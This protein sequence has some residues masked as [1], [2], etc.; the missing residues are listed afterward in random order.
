MILTYRILTYFLYPLI[1]FF[2]YFRI[3]LKKEDP[4]RF[5]EKIFIKYFNVKKSNNLKLLWF[6]AASIGEFKSIVPLIKE[7]INDK[8]NY[9]F[10]ITTTTMSSSQL[11]IKEFKNLENVHHRFMP[12][13]T[14][15]LIEN[16]LTL[17]RPEKIFLVDSEVWP[18]LILKSKEKKIPIALL[19][20][21][22]TKKSFKRWLIFPSTARKIFRIFDLCMCSN[23]ETK[24]FLEKLNAKNIKFEGN[25]KLI[26]KI[27]ENQS[28]DK[29]YS[30]LNKKRFW[31]AASIH[32]EEDI[33]CLKTH[34]EIKKKF[35]DIITFIAPRH[36]DRVNKI[37][38]LSENLNLST[39]ILNADDKILND[40][41]IIII[42]S[43]GNLQK[44]FKHAK[45][46]FIGK[47]TIKKLQND[48]GQ[49][50]IDAA[51]LGCKIYHGPYV[52][53]FKEIYEI[54]ENNNISTKVDNYNELSRNLL[55]DLENFKKKETKNT[56]I[57]QTLGHNIF[58]NTTYILK[59][60]L[61]DKIN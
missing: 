30:I 34:L 51:Y 60:F 37:K 14:E 17:W 21:R 35:N 10:L 49:N 23:K 32:K 52:Y 55:N 41:E 28:N 31:V 5:K 46:V 33:F 36:L 3:L 48:S 56:N 9:E 18:N 13:D 53:N 24:Y 8:K 25:L 43:F 12:I 38:Y 47:S 45:S 20:A 58:I 39:Q 42:N 19:N 2:I 50:P 61:N 15:H 44:Y 29:N 11:A 59:K 16:F 4:I 26:N 27:Y 1:I 40:K 57:I 54:L 6:H 7:L 22:L